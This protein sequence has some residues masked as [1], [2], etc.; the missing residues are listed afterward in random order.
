MADKIVSR[1][2]Y[3]RKEHRRFYMFHLFH[4]SSSIYLII[5]LVIILFGFTLYNVYKQQNVVFSL[6]MFGITC[7]IFPYLIISKI[8]NVV[9][10]ETPERVRS[11]DIIEV[12]KHK[13]SRANDVIS[14][15]AVIG[16]NELD[17]VCEDDEFIYLYT[18]DNSGLFIK[19]ADIV[20][21]DIESFRKIAL[22]N[23]GRDK[24]GNPRYK[25]YGNVRK[26]YNAKMNEKKKQEKLA[27]KGNK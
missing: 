5:G 18:S 11:T 26:E 2:K 13:I 27:K 10:Q 6:I 21:G 8:N 19:K 1:T 15:K 23:I 25:R 20:E 22:D 9:K 3:L 24:K 17:C 16:W 14:G 12:T 4:R 7:A